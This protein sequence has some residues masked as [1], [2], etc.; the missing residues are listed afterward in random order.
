M[1][2]LSGSLDAIAVKRA[3]TFEFVTAALVN[4]MALAVIKFELKNRLETKIKNFLFF[5]TGSSFALSS[6]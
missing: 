1:L 6:L 2:T 5:N 4:G 3:L